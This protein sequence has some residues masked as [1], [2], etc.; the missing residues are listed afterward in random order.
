MTTCPEHRT[1]Q[2]VYYSAVGNELRIIDFRYLLDPMSP[3]VQSALVMV[4]KR[5]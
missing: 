1:D 2:Y 4:Y 5:Q 3:K